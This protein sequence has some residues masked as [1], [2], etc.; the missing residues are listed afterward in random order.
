[1]KKQALTNFVFKPTGYLFFF[2][3]F[4]GDLDTDYRKLSGEGMMLNEDRQGLT[5][6]AARLISIR[7][8][9]LCQAT[10]QAT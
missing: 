4:D 5:S 8:E 2:P 3:G 6:T 9:G 7:D 10:R 1:M